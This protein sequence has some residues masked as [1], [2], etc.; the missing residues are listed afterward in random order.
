MGAQ[1]MFSEMILSKRLGENRFLLAFAH[2]K[3]E[4]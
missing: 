2:I 4:G 3:N 1:T